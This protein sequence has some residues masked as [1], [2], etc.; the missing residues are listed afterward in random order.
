METRG[1]K[2]KSDVRVPTQMG[3]MDDLEITTESHIQARWILNAFEEVAFKPRKT[4]SL[5]IWRGK[6]WRNTTLRVQGV[7]RSTQWVTTQSIPREMVWHHTWWHLQHWT[8]QASAEGRAIPGRENYRPG[9]FSMEFRAVFYGLW[10][11]MRYQH[12]LLKF[13]RPW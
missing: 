11:C 5:T 7:K 1:P 12:L 6:V 8:Y 9:C 2:A 13:W 10:R 4:R 3:F